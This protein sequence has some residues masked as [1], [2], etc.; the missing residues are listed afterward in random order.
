MSNSSYR[1]PLPF[2]I[3]PNGNKSTNP[4]VGLAAGV[5]LGLGAFMFNKLSKGKAINSEDAKK[6]VKTIQYNNK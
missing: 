6:P 3:D 1:P 2:P 5:L 4:L